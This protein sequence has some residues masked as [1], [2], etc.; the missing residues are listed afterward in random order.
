M[1]APWRSTTGVSPVQSTMVEA[2]SRAPAAG[3]WTGRG[4]ASR[5]S[6][7]RSWSISRACSA[8]R[9][10]GIPVRFADETAMGPTRSS[11]ARVTASSGTRRATV[12]WV[13]PRSHPSEGRAQHTMVR[14]P[15][16]NARARARA[17]SEISSA[18]A[19]MTSGRAMSTGG[20]ISRVR[21]LAPSSPCTPEAEKASHPMP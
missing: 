7:T 14:A 8:V 5:Y 21:P 2:A 1:M 20:G 4:P 15:G 12:P 11:T 3:S 10:A 18:R 6:T 9:A 16:Q 13:S 17:S 19:S